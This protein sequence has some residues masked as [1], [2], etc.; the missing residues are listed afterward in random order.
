MTRSSD[1]I[2]VRI[3]CRGGIE[4]RVCLDPGMVFLNPLGINTTLVKIKYE[5]C[6]SKYRMKRNL[7][8]SNVCLNFGDKRKDCTILPT[9]YSRCSLDFSSSFYTGCKKYS[10]QLRFFIFPSN[11]PQHNGSKSR[12]IFHLKN[13]PVN[14]SVLLTQRID[15][16][17]IV[18][19]EIDVKVVF[20]TKSLPDSDS[21]AL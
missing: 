14:F 8:F 19:F 9:I 5:L 12:T 10:R 17:N 15:R 13:C 11:F 20:S 1:G 16:N 18:G 3:V 21:L 6:I 2:F 4:L 7:T